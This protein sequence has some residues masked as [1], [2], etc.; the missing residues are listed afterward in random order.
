MIVATKSKLLSI[1]SGRLTVDTGDIGLDMELA[2]YVRVI[3]GYR[4]SVMFKIE[5]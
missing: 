2:G 1:A 3:T 4:D 5:S